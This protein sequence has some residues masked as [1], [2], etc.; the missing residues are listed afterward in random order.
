M[1]EASTAAERFATAVARGPDLDLAEAALLIA[2]EEYPTLSIPAYLEKLDDMALEARDR[3]RPDAPV[4][5]RIDS[6][7][8]YVFD[9]LGFKGNAED[10]YD[11]RNSFLNEVIDRRL[12]LPITLSLVYLEVARRVGVPAH[13]IG[14]PGHFIVGA[15]DGPERILIDPYHGGRRVT[16]A[17]CARIVA[18]VAGD[19]VPLREEHFAPV[20]KPQFLYRMLSNLKFVY[21]QGEASDKALR[22]IDKMRILEPASWIDVRDRGIVLHRLG[23]DPDAR[24]ELRRYLAS[25]PD[26]EDRPAVE[27]TLAEIDTILQLY[28]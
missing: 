28:R 15:G 20:G 19:P 7:N 25:V 6:L 10:Y 3:I 1:V 16:H 23:R 14:L 12:G 24:R 9:A 17:D 4:D 27:A 11:P 21:L 2:L 5:D 18:G 8:A 13:G 22:V 26:A